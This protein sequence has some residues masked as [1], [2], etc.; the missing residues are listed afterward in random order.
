MV[1]PAR[2]RQ[3]V[4]Y[5]R[6]R[7][8]LSERRACRGL[9]VARSSQRYRPRRPERDRGLIAELHR[10]GGRH[11]RYGYRRITALLRREGWPV[12]RKRVQRLWR[13]EGLKVPRRPR[14]RRRLGT[15]EQGA[16]RRRATRI[17]EVWSYD[18][19]FDSTEDGRRLKW[20]PVVDEYSREN[21][22]LEVERRIAARGV[23]ATLD[24]CVAGRGGPPDYIRS[25]NGPEFIARAVQDW[26]K[27]RGFKTLYI[28]PGAPWENPYSESFNSRLRDEFLNVESFGSL[29]EAKV[30]GRQHREQYNNQRPH[31]AL[32]D[33]T[34]AEF[35]RRCLAS[36]GATPLPSPD[37]GRDTKPEPKLS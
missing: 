35:G 12:N 20:L 37:S 9:M 23:I 29:L 15:I 25:D 28:P 30:L 13:Q 3:A 18:F 16:S 17:N 2:R 10:L 11:P 34:P 5:V 31:S 14:K 21:L 6:R 19:L 1:G 27:E 22:A 8:R 7:L 4:A 33:A 32:G 24:R 26:I 36:V